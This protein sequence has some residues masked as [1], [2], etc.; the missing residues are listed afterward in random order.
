MSFDGNTIL[1]S[2]L[3][4]SIGFVLMAYGKKMGRA[5]QLITGIVLL[6]YPYFIG[7]AVPVLCVGAGLLLLMWLA[8]RQGW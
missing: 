6:V 3:V 5:P 7:S 8:I 2:L 1:A 4:S